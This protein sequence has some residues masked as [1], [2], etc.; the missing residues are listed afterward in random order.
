VP[1]SWRE[2]LVKVR[3]VGEEV[4]FFDG[5]GVFDRIAVLLVEGGILHW[6]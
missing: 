3:N 5:P 2:A 1:F 6:P 4:N